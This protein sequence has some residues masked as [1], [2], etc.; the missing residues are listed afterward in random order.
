MHR[1]CQL[2]FGLLLG[3]LICAANATLW[4]ETGVLVVHVKDV[5][6]HPISGIQIGVEGD[7]GSAFTGDD[8]KARIALAKDTK[9]KSWVSLQIMKSPPGKDFVMVSPWDYRTIVP[10]FENESENFV[11][12]VVVRRG[13]RTALES[14]SVLAALTAQIDKANAPKT[15]DKQA[16]QENPK[17]NLAVVANQYG[18]VP[19]DL[20]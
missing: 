10:S 8:G 9:G 15:G 1:I 16:P 18:L 17:A 4:A 6:R 12:V 14:G 2:N 13:D 11:E 3:A 19:D 5:Q 7:G 20:D